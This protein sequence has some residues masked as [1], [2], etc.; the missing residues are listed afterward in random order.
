M[1]RMFAFLL[2][3][4]SLAFAQTASAAEVREFYN[5]ARSLAMGGA[6]I[7]VVNDETALLANPAALGKLRDTYGTIFDPEIDLSNNLS[8]MYNAKS[9]TNPFDL[10]SVKDV[11]NA[12]KGTYY[13][14]RANVFPSFVARN[15]GIGL[16]GKYLMDARMNDAGTELDTFYQDDLALVLGI[17]FRLFDGRIKIGASGRLISRI[18]IDK[19]DI[20]PTGSMNKKDH[21]SEGVGLATD[22]GIILAAPWVWLPTISAVV[23]DFGGTSFDTGSGV[24][25]STTDR[26]KDVAQD[27]DVGIA[28]FPIHGN[29]SRSSFTVEYQKMK[30]A[31]EAQ[32]KARY[33]HLGYEFNYGDLLFVR[34]GMNQKYWT[35]GLELASERTQIQLTSYGEDIGPDGSPEEDRRYVFKFAF[36]F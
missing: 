28:L 27:I 10:G 11:T 33:Y 6:S 30:E 7:A 2:L 36:R 17:N 5:G 29:R 31:S 35:A 32:D 19:R 1:N 22:L 12:S 24:R 26:P 34:A 15:F 8:P 16:Y 25:M 20:D 4:S 23:R 21:A 14:A 9:F 18:E 13:H 3:V